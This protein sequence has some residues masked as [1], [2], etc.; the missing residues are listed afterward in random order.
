MAVTEEEEAESRDQISSP[1]SKEDRFQLSPIPATATLPVSHLPNRQNFRPLTAEE[2]DVEDFKSKRNSPYLLR[3]IE[4]IPIRPGVQ[5]MNSNSSLLSRPD[6]DG[7]PRSLPRSLIDVHMAS[8]SSSPTAAFQ[9]SSRDRERFDDSMSMQ[10][11]MQSYRNGGVSRRTSLSSHIHPREHD[12]LQERARTLNRVLDKADTSKDAPVRIF[13]RRE[14]Q[15]SPDTSAPTTR[16]PS[17]VSAGNSQMGPPLSKPQVYSPLL[18]PPPQQ[19]VSW[20]SAAA[21]Q[22]ER[23]R[24]NSIKDSPSS[25]TSLSPTSPVKPDR[26][27]DYGRDTSAHSVTPSQQYQPRRP[28]LGS[29]RAKSSSNTSVPSAAS[30]L[31][32]SFWGMQEPQRV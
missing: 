3:S 18:Q 12:E 20:A 17:P 5:R 9:Y 19:T 30:G 6:A 28:S 1:R 7:V 25:P 29:M 13:D 4:P 2:S 21:L 16:T 32:R 22:A 10:D 23:A 24:A 27:R 26:T 15:R 14:R 8:C 31:T 11:N